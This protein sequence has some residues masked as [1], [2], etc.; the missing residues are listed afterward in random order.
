MYI[1]TY[2][3]VCMRCLLRSEDL[4]G[5]AAQW[6]FGKKARLPA[7][8]GWVGWVWGV[9]VVVVVVVVDVDVN[10]DVNVDVDVDVVVD[11]AVVAH[12][13]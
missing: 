8:Q 9:V 5:A 4:G 12:R 3:C 6:V 11:V 1:C 2:V 13:G 7:Q 10:V